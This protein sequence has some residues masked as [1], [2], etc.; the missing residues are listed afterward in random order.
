MTARMRRYLCVDCGQLTRRERNHG[1]S[2]IC[3]ECGVKRG[4]KGRPRKTDRAASQPAASDRA[5]VGG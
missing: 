2:L 1:E 3:F 5:K 4:V